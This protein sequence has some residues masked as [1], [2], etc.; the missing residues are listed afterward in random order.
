[1]PRLIFRL[2]LDVFERYIAHIYQTF[3]ICYAC[4]PCTHQ[5]ETCRWFYKSVGCDLNRT[6][7]KFR[8]SVYCRHVAPSRN[9]EFTCYFDLSQCLNLRTDC[10]HQ[11]N[12]SDSAQVFSRAASNRE[13]RVVKSVNNRNKMAADIFMGNANLST[14][15]SHPQK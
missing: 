14:H 15:T 2:N 5:M 6:L 1:M 12:L 8:R 7:V 13:D 11:V 9:L 4:P 10:S 3:S